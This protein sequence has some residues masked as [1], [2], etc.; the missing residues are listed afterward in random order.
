MC[1]PAK[2]LTFGDLM[3]SAFR[4]VPQTTRRSRAGGSPLFYALS[5][6]GISPHLA[7]ERL[8]ICLDAN[9][10]KIKHPQLG[11]AHFPPCPD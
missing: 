10:P 3:T 1:V 5:N 11:A 2:R 4:T 9:E 7:G 8:F 6:L